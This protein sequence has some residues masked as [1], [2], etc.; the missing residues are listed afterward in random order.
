[1]AR[2]TH[3]KV[4][5][6]HLFSSGKTIQ[7]VNLILKVLL[8]QGSSFSSS[9]IPRSFPPNSTWKPLPLGETSNIL[10]ATRRAGPEVQSGSETME[11]PQQAGWLIQTTLPKKTGALP[12]QGQDLT[13]TRKHLPLSP[14]L[15]FPISFPPKPVS[16]YY[17][18]LYNC[19][20]L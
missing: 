17:S 13:T 12:G 20:R 15:T 6:P 3:L 8:A 2:L 7:F 18:F 11:S 16:D 9:Q 14:T 19:L 5:H 1:M 10:T 4:S